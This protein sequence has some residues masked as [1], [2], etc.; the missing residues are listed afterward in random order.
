MSLAELGSL[1]IR[2]KIRPPPGGGGVPS[3]APSFGGVLGVFFFFFFL[4]L[5]QIIGDFGRSKA[6]SFK[7]SGILSGRRP[8][9]TSFNGH[10]GNLPVG[11]RAA[12]LNPN[13][14]TT[15]C[16]QCGLKS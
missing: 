4:D 10:M 14:A 13:T 15:S 8:V 3:F 9:I 1:G 5:I 2:P 6:G 11:V 16:S 12:N 7:L